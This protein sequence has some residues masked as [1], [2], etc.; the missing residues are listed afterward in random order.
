MRIDDEEWVEGYPALQ[1]RARLQALN[2]RQTYSAL[3]KWYTK[4]KA[5]ILHQETLDEAKDRVQE[6]MGLR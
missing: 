4:K 3:L 1:D 6:I 2:A 5:P